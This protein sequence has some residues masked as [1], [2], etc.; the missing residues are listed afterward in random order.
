[1][2]DKPVRTLKPSPINSTIIF[3]SPRE[4]EARV[5]PREA[6]IEATLARLQTALDR[7]EVRQQSALNSL[8]ENYDAKAKH[9]RRVLGELGVDLGKLPLAPPRAMGGP[10]VMT[11]RTEIT[12]AFTEFH[13]GKFGDIPRQ[14]RLKYR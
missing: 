13:S 3:G 1:M 7:I 9:I 5:D 4:R 8:E 6:G 14:A 10:F 12:K 2:G 11:T